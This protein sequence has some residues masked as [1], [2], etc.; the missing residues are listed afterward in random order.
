MTISNKI[1]KELIKHFGNWFSG[2]SEFR[3]KN[4][5]RSIFFTAVFSDKLCKF[6]DDNL[7]SHLMLAH[8]QFMRMFVSLFNFGL[9]IPK[10][11]F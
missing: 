7:D 9:S 1:Q 3:R 4:Q 6:V 8:D 10:I 11:V 2:S 5:W